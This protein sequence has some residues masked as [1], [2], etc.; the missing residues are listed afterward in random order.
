[1]RDAHVTAGTHADGPRGAGPAIEAPDSPH[2]LARPGHRRAV[3]R[4]CRRQPTAAPG[5]TPPRWPSGTGPNSSR[6]VPAISDSTAPRHGSDVGPFGLFGSARNPWIPVESGRIAASGVAVRP[7]WEGTES[8]PVRGPAFDVQ[9]C[10]AAAPATLCWF[11]RAV[12]DGRGGGRTSTMVPEGD[13][14]RIDAH[15]TRQP[16][17]FPRARCSALLPVAAPADRHPSH[18][19]GQTFV[20]G[21]RAIPVGRWWVS[22]R[23]C[24]PRVHTWL[25]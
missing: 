13:G 23:G 1:M 25:V 22:R 17:D 21:P 11:C 5:P 14:A 4:A 15:P 20:T 18:P 9:R 16:E 3:R 19:V 10:R 24:V 12:P 6:C 8:G 7:G 2:L